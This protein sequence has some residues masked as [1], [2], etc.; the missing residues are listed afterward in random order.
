MLLSR[1]TA[2]RLSTPS[3]LDAALRDTDKAIHI[4]PGSWNAW[5][6]RGEVLLASADLD[7]AEEAFQNALERAPRMNQLQAQSSLAYIREK[8]AAGKIM[9]K[10]K[11][12]STM[13]SQTETAQS[14]ALIPLPEASQPGAGTARGPVVL[15]EN[16]PSDPPP[17]YSAEPN[18]SPRR[19]TLTIA[20][21]NDRLQSLGFDLAPRNKGRLKVKPYKSTHSIKAVRL[22]YVGMTNLELTSRELSTPTYLHESQSEKPS[23]QNGP[24]NGLTHHRKM[25]R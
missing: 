14:P 6:A 23:F 25:A 20:Y 8:R 2:Y 9:P 4:L 22:V 16:V 18:P 3:K 5:H 13:I 10:H 15:P 17:R 1:A 24:P 21:I 19:S 12:P 11:P 7:A